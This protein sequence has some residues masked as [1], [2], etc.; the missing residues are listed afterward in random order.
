MAE[1][2]GSPYVIKC[3]IY[4]VMALIPTL[5]SCFFLRTMILNKQKKNKGKG[6]VSLGSERSD[7]FDSERS[8]LYI[9]SSAKS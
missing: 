1:A 9:V 5:L 6:K 4:T 7:I 3:A 2:I 8:E